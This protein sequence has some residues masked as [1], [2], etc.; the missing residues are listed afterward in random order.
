MQTIKVYGPGCS[1]CRQTED[2]VRKVVKE[3]GIEAEVVGIHD[4]QAIAAAGIMGTPAIAIDGVIKVAGRIP[5]ASEI[6]QWLTA[7]K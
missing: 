4:M 5:K 1:R 3:N 6:K 2:L 7:D